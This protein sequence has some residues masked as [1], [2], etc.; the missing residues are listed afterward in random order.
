MRQVL[1]T[2]GAGFIGSHLVEALVRRGDAVR[3][4]DNLSTGREQNLAAV[5]DAV[6]LIQGDIRDRDV[7]H[8]SMA[9]T[10]LVFHQAALV[11]VPLSVQEPAL[12]HAINVD[13]TFHV[14]DVARQVGVRCLVYASSSAVY[15]D[16][17]GLPKTE[18]M[19]IAPL[20]PYGLAKLVG[21]RY[22]GLFHTCYG[23]PAIGLRYLNVYGPR[24]DPGSPY[25]GVISIFIDRLL[26]G[27]RPTIYGDGQQ[28]RDFVYVADVVRANLL[29]AETP[30]ASGEVLNVSTGRPVTINAL[31]ATLQDIA[32]T[33]L[34]PH[35]AEERKGDIRHSSASF[36]KARWMV[37]YEPRT[38]LAEGLRH[39]L[40]WY[41][42]QQ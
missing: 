8:R 35:F 12:N 34:P 40:E 25:S 41:R 37:G 22:A 33:D 32:G 14:M 30:A 27:R 26:A 18:E 15:G 39:T 5:A 23:L 42:G 6:E 4:L 28:T 3:V 7:V 38:S 9:G 19:E 24:Q 13:G 11:S 2:G 16:L 31:W 1:V 36:E 29:A 17:P 10:D 21:E 20:S